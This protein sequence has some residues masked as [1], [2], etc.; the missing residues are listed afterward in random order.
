MAIESVPTA[1][2]AAQRPTARP[3]PEIAG[4]MRLAANAIATTA[5]TWQWRMLPTVGELADV[6]AK[7]R[8]LQHCLTEMRQAAQEAR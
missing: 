7:L 4:D 2:P 3:V 5:R 6:D 8:G 1:P